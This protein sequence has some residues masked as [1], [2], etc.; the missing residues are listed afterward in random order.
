MF[1]GE[2]TGNEMHLV[3][4]EMQMHV[5]GYKSSAG[6]EASRP[7]TMDRAS[8]KTNEGEASI[9]LRKALRSERGQCAAAAVAP[10]KT[11]SVAVGR[12]WVIRPRK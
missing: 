2:A 12:A 11:A 10:R 1:E 6:Y 5:A 8:T 4:I 9:R 7:P 3:E